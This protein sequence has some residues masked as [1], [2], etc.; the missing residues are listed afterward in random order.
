M[1]KINDKGRFEVYFDGK[2][3]LC[4][5]EID[6]IRWKDK[7]HQRLTLV[8]IAGP[9]FDAGA[10][11][12][13]LDEFHRE[14]YGRD[15]AGNWVTGVDVFREIYQR[16]GFAP[17]ARLSELPII[18][19]VLGVGYLGF[20]NLRYRTA[21]RRIRAAAKSGPNQICETSCSPLGEGK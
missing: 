15:Q 11:G 10:Y 19:S 4:R 2:C 12:K 7:K 20:A 16:I 3:P 8:D 1:D 21:L 14:I 9:K 5:R 13:T 6:L 18:R 17:F